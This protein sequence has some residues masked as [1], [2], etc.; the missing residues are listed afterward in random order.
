MIVSIGVSGIEEKVAFIMEVNKLL[1]EPASLKLPQHPSQGSKRM[2]AVGQVSAVRTGAQL[3]YLVSQ[4][5][6]LR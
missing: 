3:F 4:M 1:W 2:L 5:D 6:A